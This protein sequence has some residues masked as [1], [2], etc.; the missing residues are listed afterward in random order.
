LKIPTDK[1]KELRELS[2]AGIMACRNA[3]L[4]AEQ[5]MEKAMQILKERNL[6]IADKK[7][8][9]TTSQ[10]LIE[11]YVHTGGRIAA[12]IELNC[13]TDFVA[14]TDEFKALAHQ[15]AMQVAAQDP[16]FISPEM[17]PEGADIEP[18][19]A[20]LL[21]QP[22]IRDPGVTV[23]DVINDTIGKVGENIRVSRF[24]RFELGEQ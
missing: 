3:L 17:V 10:G 1:L 6:Y 5:D 14:R 9:R 13:E 4:E 18:E 11:A 20:C 2:G 16:Q 24:A 19:E 15:L 23:Q 21:L 22:Y 7:K 8:E 12:M